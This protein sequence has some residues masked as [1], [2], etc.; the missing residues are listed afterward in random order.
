MECFSVSSLREK[1]P[2]TES[3]LVRIQSECG[4]IRMAPYLGTFHAV[5]PTVIKPVH[6]NLCYISVAID[7]DAAS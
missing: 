1:C 5:L 7:Y 4:K 3:F 2:N 6:P